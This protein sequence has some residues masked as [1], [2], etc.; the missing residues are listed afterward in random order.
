MESFT[1]T[2]SS[3]FLRKV[4]GNRPAHLSHKS[5]LLEETHTCWPK[6]HAKQA[7]M[8]SVLSENVSIGWTLLRCASSETQIQ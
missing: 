7:L 1:Q 8:S 6:G 4:E 2:I 5:P 3:G